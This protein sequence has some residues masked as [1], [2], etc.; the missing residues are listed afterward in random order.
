MTDQKNEVKTS[1]SQSSHDKKPGFSKLLNDVVPFFRGHS[2]LL[3]LYSFI[4][5]ET[6][7]GVFPTSK[8]RKK[9]TM[10]PGEFI[11]S[12]TNLRKM[13]GVHLYNIHYQLSVLQEMGV[14]QSE[15]IGKTLIKIVPTNSAKMHAEDATKRIKKP[16]TKKS[17]APE[18]SNGSAPNRKQ[19]FG[20]EHLNGSGL[21]SLEETN[22]SAPNISSESLIITKEDY[23]KDEGE[24]KTENTPPL[25]DETPAEITALQ[26][27]GDALFDKWQMGTITPEENA[28]A[29]EIADKIKAYYD[30][31]K[32]TQIAKPEPSKPLEE[33]W[34]SLITKS[35]R[36][37]KYT[38]LELKEIAGKCA[39]TMT[40]MDEKIGFDVVLR[41]V[42]NHGSDFLKDI[43]F[44]SPKRIFDSD[45]ENCTYLEEALKKTNAHI[46]RLERK[47]RSAR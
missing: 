14:I 9:I 12:L 41:W 27:E 21:N 15:K 19:R 30:S 47:K 40:T 38:V 17:K 10:Q 13:A 37:S 46:E 16:L 22:G 34:H 32:P 18:T 36:N 29:D 11:T 43:Y 2:D 24:K 1:K 20:P 7:W 39:A 3:G 23:F 4:L 25:D 8:F 26:N 33:Y 45:R 6:A 44:K 31:L 35:Y 42:N 5:H 28:R